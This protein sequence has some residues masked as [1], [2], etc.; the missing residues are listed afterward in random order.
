MKKTILC[1]VFCLVSI[2]GIPCQGTYYASGIS[3]YYAYVHQ[4]LANCCAG[5]SISVVMID[6]GVS[7][8]HTNTSHGSNSSCSGDASI[9]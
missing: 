5:T 2:L 4:H 8:G 6:S 3:D 9:S 7:Y 1:S